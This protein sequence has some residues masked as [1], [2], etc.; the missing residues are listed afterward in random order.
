M[1]QKKVVAKMNR[2]FENNLN[3]MALSI[4][5]GHMFTTEQI[6][7]FKKYGYHG[8]YETKDAI[9]D[10]MSAVNALEAQGKEM[11]DFKDAHINHHI[12]HI[13]AKLD[14]LEKRVEAHE[15]ETRHKT[16]AEQH[17][18]G[19]HIPAPEPVCETCGGTG[20]V[21]S[22]GFTPWMEPIDI[23]CPSCQPKSCEN[24]ASGGKDDSCHSAYVIH[25]LKECIDLG[26]KYWTPKPT[27]EGEKYPHLL[28]PR[29]E[30]KGQTAPDEAWLRVGMYVKVICTNNA[31]DEYV[32][33]IGRI[34]ESLDAGY[35]DSGEPAYAVT[36]PDGETWYY[37]SKRLN[38]TDLIPA[39]RLKRAEEL[40]DRAWTRIPDNNDS[41]RQLVDDI[42][43]YF[44]S[45]EI[46]AFREGRG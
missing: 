5:G 35:L 46:D 44:K 14:A 20:V 24:C 17:G 8:R 39:F 28:N 30:V 1:E 9:A 25:R 11:G 32:G 36:F 43:K 38:L 12:S 16:F 37:S 40:L 2:I 41:C 31:P 23:P 6:E 22:G 29:V 45:K 15:K 7:H 21:D 33:K 26:R 34:T 3:Y 10:L 13:N 4:N 19:Q 42:L 18:L 27:E